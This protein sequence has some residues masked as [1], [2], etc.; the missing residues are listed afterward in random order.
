MGRSKSSRGGVPCRDRWQAV[1]ARHRQSG[2]SIKAFCARERVSYQSFFLWKRRFRDEAADGK[3]TFTPVRVV[4]EE[5]AQAECGHI[6][7]ELPEGSR[8]HVR[9][10]VDRQALADVLAVLGVVA[11]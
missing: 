4:T 10:R 2:L 11:C 9:G 6:E 5:P 1:L 8:V 7:I 3:V